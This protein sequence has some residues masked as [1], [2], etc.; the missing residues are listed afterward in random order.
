MKKGQIY[1]E[2]GKYKLIK[3]REDCHLEKK[4]WCRC[5]TFKN[6]NNFI[7]FFLASVLK[8]RRF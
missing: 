3:K 7:N 4:A 5:Y 2:E 8:K 1:L 6:H